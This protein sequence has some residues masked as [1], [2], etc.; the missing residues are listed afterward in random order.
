MDYVRIQNKNTGGS[1]TRFVGGPSIGHWD[2]QW[3]GLHHKLNGPRGASDSRTSVLGV[4]GPFKTSTVENYTVLPLPFIL[5]SN[6]FLV[7]VLFFVN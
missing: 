1:L 7:V 5:L 4:L 6:T 2:P 3:V